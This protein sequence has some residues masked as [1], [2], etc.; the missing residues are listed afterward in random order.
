MFVIL[1]QAVWLR[2]SAG[3]IFP[4]RRVVVFMSAVYR[5]IRGRVAQA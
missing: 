1:P 3:N 5:L 4:A 2:Q